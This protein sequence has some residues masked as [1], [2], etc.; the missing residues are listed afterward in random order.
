MVSHSQ[1]N[2]KMAK[3]KSLIKIEGTLDGMTFYKGKDGYLVRTKGGISKNRIQNDPAF[4][5]TR[6]NGTEFGQSARSGKLLR[7]ALTPVLADVKD[8]TLTARMMKIM[9]QI[10]NADTTSARGS[11]VVANGI[12][13]TEGK[14]S[15]KEFDFNSNAKLKGVLLADYQ[16][17]PATGEV[18]ITNFN[19]IQQMNSP[20]GATHVSFSSGVLNLNFETGDKELQISPEVNLSI[21]ATPTDI[22]LVP[23][24]LPSGSGQNL[25][26][27]KLTFFQEI[28]G[29]Q[30]VLNNGT[31][32]VLHI[33]EIL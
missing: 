4:I 7:Q 15:L 1:H 30:Y 14:A 27:M 28:N 19:P 8:S 22:S 24:A 16:L 21:N 31:F 12:T 32:N 29:V 3:L 23:V 33:M 18:T 11:R 13:S 9:T 25:F 10:K 17:D 26:L 2:L 6:E 5:R 20:G